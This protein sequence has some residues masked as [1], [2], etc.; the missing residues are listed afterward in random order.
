M[1]SK[2]EIL[3]YLEEEEID[4]NLVSNTISEYLESQEIQ[5]NA[6]ECVICLEKIE[7]NNFATNF[8]CAHNKMMHKKCVTSLSKCPLCR[9]FINDR[10]DIINNTGNRQFESFACFTTFSLICLITFGLSQSMIM[11]MTTGTY[12]NFNSTNIT[13]I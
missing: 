10:S 2:F 13:N 6:N 1:D 9:T 5:L 4:K 11:G 8:P 7:E 3:K 12:I